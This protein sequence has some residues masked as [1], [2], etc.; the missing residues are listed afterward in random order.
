MFKSLSLATVATCA[1]MASASYAATVDFSTN[2]GAAL[3]AG[4]VVTNFDFGSNLTGVVSA[5]GNSATSPDLA[6]VFDTNNPS[7]GDGDLAS[8]F[9]PVGGGVGVNFGN[10][11]IVQESGMA[12]FGPDDP[13]DD[14]NGG[15]ITFTF[16][17]DAI[18]GAFNLLDVSP[19]VIVALFD[20]GGGLVSSIVTTEDADSGNAPPNFF[21][22]VDFNDTVARSFTVD[23][24][25][26]SG[27][28]G[29]FEAV[30]TVPLPAPLP[31]LAFGLIGAG[32]AMRRRQK[33]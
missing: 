32:Y 28:F 9:Q 8:D 15:T 12:P 5:N 27:G 11:L 24:G 4:D 25:D 10:A 13:D 30:S 3:S 29:S 21:T 23:F 19:G 20:G 14:G 1:A 31:M 7:G 33:A 22:T 17:A 6:V 26:R 18:F 2:N 16:D